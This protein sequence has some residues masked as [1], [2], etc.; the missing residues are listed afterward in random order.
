MLRQREHQSSLGCIRGAPGVAGRTGLPDAPNGDSPISDG[1]ERTTN[2]LEPLDGLPN[3]ERRRGILDWPIFQD[4]AFHQRASRSRACAPTIVSVHI[5]LTVRRWHPEA[6]T[7]ASNA[8]PGVE[9]RFP[10]FPTTL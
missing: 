2:E 10:M 3:V 9:R 5:T 6:A 4:F 7:D 8:K 1:T